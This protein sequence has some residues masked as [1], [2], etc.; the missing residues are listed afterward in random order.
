M[1]QEL[2]IQSLPKLKPTKREEKKFVD[3]FMYLLTSPALYYPQWTPPEP[4]LKD[5]MIHLLTDYKC[6]EREECSDYDA[7]IYVQ[8]AS[9][10]FPLDTEWFNIFMWLFMKYYKDEAPSEWNEEH[11]RELSYCEKHDLLRLKQWIFKKQIEHIKAKNKEEKE[12]VKEEEKKKQ[13]NFDFFVCKSEG[14]KLG[15]DL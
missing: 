7:L 15:V 2:V 8:T 14:E 3:H 10:S 12:V 5:R 11:G 9:M 1:K 4:M 13:S 6:F